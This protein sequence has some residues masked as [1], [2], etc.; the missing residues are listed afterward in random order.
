MMV[1][2]VSGGSMSKGDKRRP[3]N[4]SNEEYTDNYNR[5]FKGVEPEIPTV[6]QVE[7]TAIV[8]YVLPD[9]GIDL[10][11]MDHPTACKY[12]VKGMKVKLLRWANN[13]ERGWNKVW[14]DA[15]TA[16]IGKVY[17]IESVDSIEGIHFVEI[18]CWYPAF[19]LQ[20]IE[21]ENSKCQTK[22]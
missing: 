4:I 7:C 19:C 15:M 11:K 16:Y 8:K 9:N 18:G 17:T 21:Q 14:I 5:I 1:L 12:L 13:F 6:T 10:T 22:E 2:G 20:I 3:S